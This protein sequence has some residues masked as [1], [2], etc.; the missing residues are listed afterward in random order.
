MIE[1]DNDQKPFYIQS[2]KKGFGKRKNIGQKKVV[3]EKIFVE[4]FKIV[5]VVK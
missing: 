5:I 3:H 4:T 1:L 2:E